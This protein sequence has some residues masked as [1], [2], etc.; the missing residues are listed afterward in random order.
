MRVEKGVSGAY[1]FP[2]SKII[3]RVDMVC[4]GPIIPVGHR[5]W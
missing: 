3:V 5:K 2:A 1:N 4:V